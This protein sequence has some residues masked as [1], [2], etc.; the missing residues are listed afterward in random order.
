MNERMFDGKKK[1]KRQ[2]KN[3]SALLFASLVRGSTA[4]GRDFNLVVAFG[5]WC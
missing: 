2:V 4:I 1:Q 3:K 5:D